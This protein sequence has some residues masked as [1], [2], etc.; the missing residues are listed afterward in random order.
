MAKRIVLYTTSKKY[1]MLAIVVAS[2]QFQ[3]YGWHLQQRQQSYL[4]KKIQMTDDSVY[5]P[6]LT[7]QLVCHLWL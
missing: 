3:S 4:Q 6:T 1:F 2:H 7:I 5:L